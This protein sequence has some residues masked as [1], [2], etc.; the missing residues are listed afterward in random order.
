MMSA[1]MASPLVVLVLVVLVALVQLQ[2]QL[3]QE[4]G[5]GGLAQANSFYS[6]LRRVPSRGGR[7]MCATDPYV[8]NAE[9]GERCCRGY[10]T[11]VRN[12][13]VNCGVCRRTCA[14]GLACCSGTCVNLLTSDRHCGSCSNRCAANVTCESGICGYAY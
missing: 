11:S 8:C 12:D 1:F 10:C 9:N 5:G 6:P 13:A 2:L 3:Q 7:Q 4:E 14:S